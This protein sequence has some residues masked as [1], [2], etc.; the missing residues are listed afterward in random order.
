MTD[1]EKCKE[2][3]LP[4][5]RGRDVK[6]LSESL[7]NI[8]KRNPVILDQEDI[9]EKEIKNT[10]EPKDMLNTYVSYVKWSK[11]SFPNKFDKTLK[12]LEVI[13]EVYLQIIPFCISAAPVN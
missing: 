11:D 3:V 13:Y 10:S 5:K 12:L 1:W 8:S 4:V 7:D 2:N 9:F 6:G